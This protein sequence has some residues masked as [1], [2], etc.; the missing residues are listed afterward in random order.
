[1]DEVELGPE[2]RGVLGDLNRTPREL[3][4]E[5]LGDTG[6]LIARLCRVTPSPRLPAEP[7]SRG[8][9]VREDSLVEL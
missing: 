4:H 8:Q 2:S 9:K 5:G 6:D 1:M 3:G 7:E